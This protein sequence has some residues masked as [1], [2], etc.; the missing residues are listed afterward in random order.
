MLR[1]LINEVNRVGVNINQ[2]VFNH[3][4][5]NYSKV[6]KESLTAYMRK[7]NLEVRNVVEKIGD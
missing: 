5:E 3:H 4:T 1:E 7:L 2:I 6:D